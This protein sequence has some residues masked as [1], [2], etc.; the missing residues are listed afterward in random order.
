MRW[1]SRT[2]FFAVPASAMFTVASAEVCVSLLKVT[3]DTL[4]GGTT[5]DRGGGGFCGGGGDD[6]V[7]DL[8]V[9][10]LMSLLRDT[11]VWYPVPAVRL[12]R[13]KVALPFI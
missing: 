6:V 2:V 12:L 13:M 3:S 1:C 8:V 11:L 7:N 9:A 10:S 5:G 4:G